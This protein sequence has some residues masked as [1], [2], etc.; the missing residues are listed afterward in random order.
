MVQLN[1]KLILCVISSFI[2]RNVDL[3]AVDVVKKLEDVSLMKI[4]F[5]K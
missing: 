5:L 2:L 3:G 4:I 1:M